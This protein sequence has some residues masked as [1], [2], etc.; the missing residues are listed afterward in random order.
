MDHELRF[1]FIP[2][3]GPGGTGEY[4]RSLAIARS[5]ERRWPSARIT[6]VVSRDALYATQ[7]PY[8][9]H[10]INRSPTYETAA[11]NAIVREERPHVVVFDSAGRVAQYRAARAVG[12]RVVFISSRPTTRRKG[13]RLRRMRHCDQHWLAQPQFLGGQLTLSE[14]ARLLLA[15]NLEL[16]FLDVLY[17]PVDSAGTAQLLERL[18]ITGGEFALCCPGGGGVFAK[19]PN[20]TALFYEAAAELARS[21]SLPVIA[22]LG[23]RFQPPTTRPPT[24]HVFPTLPNALL[25][26]LLHEARVALINGGSLLVQALAQGAACVAAP[27]AE[28]QPA[29]I[30][31]ASAQG[32]VVPAA[33]DVVALCEATL[34]LLGDPV[35]RADLRRR[36]AELGLRNGIDVA[37]EAIARLVPES[38]AAAAGP[39]GGG[40]LRVLQV[41][42]S[43]GFAGSERAV[44]ETC[45]ELCG[46][47]DVAL[48]VRSDHRSRS[49]ASIVDH[50]DPRVE[51]FE[52]APHW[53]TRRALYRIMDRWRA[54][55]VHTHLRRGTR[56]VAQKP[57]RPPHVCTL[58][59]SLNG[60]HF[61]LADGI[62]CI[63]QWQTA[64]I[65]KS[66]RGSV[67]MIPNSLVS[68]PRI[69]DRRRAQ[70]RA[71]CGAESGEF[72]IGGVGRLVYSKGFDLLLEAFSRAALPDA[73]LVIIGEGSARG[74]LERAA[75]DRVRFMGFRAD[76]KDC[77]QALDVFVSP[78]RSEPFG[79][80]IVEALDAGVPVI[81]T[82]TRGPLDMAGSL[83]LRLVPC[84]D[85]SA[86][87]EVLRSAYEVRTRPVADLSS[88]Q[89]GH[90]VG[91]LLDAY[92][93][94]QE[95]SVT[96]S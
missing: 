79:R 80:V 85:V 40:R 43:R 75:P 96:G 22:V 5:V 19:G 59:L 50:L 72:L 33:L 93:L 29:R 56:Y 77:L 54:D 35:R 17:E 25:M 69:D 45:N 82:R 12:A 11:V 94:V 81:A 41:L 1:L 64:T 87:A 6:F 30:A 95:R 83:P 46:A 24:L 67:F 8:P 91:Q 27:I 32:L 9:I 14:R 34:R 37:V 26:G 16:A 84:E 52:V 63:S 3:S 88:Y 49:G 47:H 90:V 18:G 71:E 39:S 55:V 21:Q 65:P 10:L 92:R 61:V 57:D 4:F 2:V 15:P 44:A 68:Q 20:A 23:T 53:S 51:L 62:I 60:P 13:F 89:L 7:C 73:R 86:L 38:C 28:D 74:A 76:V 42:L 48:V 78:S 70:L 66:Y 58:H 31:A 36:G